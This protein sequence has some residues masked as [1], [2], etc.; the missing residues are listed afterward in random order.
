MPKKPKTKVDH[1][2]LHKALEQIGKD[3]KKAA[4]A[5]NPFEGLLSRGG[6]LDGPYP[7]VNPSEHPQ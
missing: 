2:Q 1:A 4:E 6:S 3:Q 7:R 5:P